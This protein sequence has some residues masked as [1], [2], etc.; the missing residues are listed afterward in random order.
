MADLKY[1]L[2]QRLERARELRAEG[3]VCSQCVMMCFP[4]V[5][6]LTDKQAASIA[7]GLGGGVGGQ[8]DICGCVSA[9]AM[10]SG[11]ASEGDPKTKAQTYGGVRALCQQ[12]VQENGS[13][14]CRELKTSGRKPCMQLIESAVTIFHNKLEENR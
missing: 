10:L 9:M 12:F 13:L 1:T 14:Q 2:T 6:S 11:F 5:H 4:D 3:H 7:I 8:G